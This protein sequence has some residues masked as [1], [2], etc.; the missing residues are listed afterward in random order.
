MKRLS[1]LIAFIA[2][3]L[4]LVCFI[5]PRFVYNAAKE[6][7]LT[8]I[9]HYRVFETVNAKYDTIYTIGEY[10]ARGY[11]HLNAEWV[12]EGWEDYPPHGPSSYQKKYFNR[13]EVYYL[14]AELNG[15][16]K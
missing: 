2:F 10:V 3:Y 7:S 11:V 4:I 6:P 1:V 14:V 16:V 13:K 5:I 9:P 15:R 12:E 8:P